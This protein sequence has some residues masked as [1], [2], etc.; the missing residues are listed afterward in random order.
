LIQSIR[1][2]CCCTVCIAVID[3]EKMI[4]MVNLYSASKVK[5]VDLG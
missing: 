1:A 3:A 2:F 5:N 4:N